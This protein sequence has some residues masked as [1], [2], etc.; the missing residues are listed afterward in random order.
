MLTTLGAGWV[1]ARFLRPSGLPLLQQELALATLSSVPLALTLRGSSV[2]AYHGAEHVAIGS[3]EHDE[4]RTR[5]HER[6]GSHL[7]LPILGATAVGNVIAGRLAR[8]RAG[9][10]VGRSLAAGVAL[11]LSVELFGWMLRNPDEPLARALAAPGG[12]L[13]RNFLTR[14][15]SGEQV[16]VAQAALDECLRLE[17]AA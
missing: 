11:G 15:P 1:C 17:R 10:A 8:T 3:W 9:G 7:A 16:E 14:E 4:P 5:I 13:Q 6:C 12:W 2:A